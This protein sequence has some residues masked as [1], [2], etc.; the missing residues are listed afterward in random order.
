MARAQ[1]VA[2]ADFVPLAG[3]Y[4]SAGASRRDEAAEPKNVRR[5]AKLMKVIFLLPAF[6][7]GQF[8]GQRFVAEG[9]EAK[10]TI[11]IIEV[12]DIAIVFKRV[13]WFEFTPLFSVSITMV[14]EAYFRLVEIE[15]SG[16]VA[17]IQKADGERA[18]YKEL[19]HYRIFLD[20]AGCFDVAAES[21]SFAASVT[22]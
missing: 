19:H 11:H 4:Y 16:K 18:P 20:E 13:R 5:A 7:T 1:V 3:L 9:S 12:G 2:A 8:A 10:L 15:N 6:D 22:A 21:A 17:E 14:K